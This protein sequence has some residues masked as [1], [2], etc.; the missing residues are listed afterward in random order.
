MET[1]DQLKL[2]SFDIYHEYGGV[3]KRALYCS[4]FQSPA[5]EMRI[6]DVN[7]KK[8]TD[9]INA[10]LSGQI[11]EK[12]VEECISRRKVRTTDIIYVLS[13]KTI[14]TFNAS[15]KTDDIQ[16]FYNGDIRQVQTII[17]AAKQYIVK[18]QKTNNFNLIIPGNESFCLRSIKNKKPKLSLDKSYNDDL[19]ELHP[20]ILKSLRSSETSGL[21]LLHGVPGTGKS[22]YIRYLANFIN[23][24]IIFFPPNL[25]FNLSDPSF[26]GFLIDNKN[27]IILIEDAEELLVSR[28]RGNNSGISMLL[29][30]TDG[31]L[32]ASLNIQ[33]ICTFNTELQNIDTALLRKGRLT[34][35]YE[36]K[37]LTIEKSKALLATLG[38]ENI[39]VT[40]P[41]TL[42]D[43]YKSDKQKFNFKPER[44][45]IGFRAA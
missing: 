33:F 35:L 5:C 43:I 15:L 18:R 42:A 3:S 11:I 17:D 19:T 2:H 31:L 25:A 45:T 32:G 6:Y 21:V 29:N 14:I 36:F 26:T 34:A 10:N 37:P 9:W 4:Y 20:Q 13:G 30:L 1:T 39:E 28:N 12:I 16:I 8:I 44:N 38:E 40:E 23:K 24:K 27:T 22:T 7:I 41:M